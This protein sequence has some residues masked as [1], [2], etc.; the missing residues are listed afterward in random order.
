MKTVDFIVSYF[1]V[2]SIEAEAAELFVLFNSEVTISSM[3]FLLLT[4]MVKIDVIQKPFKHTH[5]LG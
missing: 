5:M 4:L 3:I 2:F 1:K